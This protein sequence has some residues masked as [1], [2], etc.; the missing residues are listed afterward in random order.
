MHHMEIKTT[1]AGVSVSYP[2]LK[3]FVVPLFQA[4]RTRIEALKSSVNA[5][6]SQVDGPH[7]RVGSKKISTKPLKMRSVIAPKCK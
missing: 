3:L 1:T 7:N 5:L 2:A 4:I 6:L